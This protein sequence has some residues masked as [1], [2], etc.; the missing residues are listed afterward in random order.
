MKVETNADVKELDERL[1]NELGIDVRKYR[2][3]EV[4]ENFMEILLFPQYIGSWV[5]RP[6][7]LLLILFFLGFFFIDLVH[8]EYLIYAVFGL[9]LTLLTGLFLGLLLFTWRLKSDL[10]GIV[11]YALGIMKSGATDLSQVSNKITPDNRKEVLGL[12][13]KGVIHIVTIPMMGEV[14]SKKVPFFGGAIKS[15]LKRV[16]T[17]VSDTVKFDET[18]LEAELNKEDSEPGFIETYTNSISAAT[19]GLNTALSKTMGLAQFPLKIGFLI[20][21]I[22]LVTFLYLIW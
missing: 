8:I 6:I 4:A 20:S 16:L 13:F 12:L 1:K 14:A 17:I 10:I 18:L 3:E 7:I 22:S 19:A 5:L 11:E 9:A 21:M 15:L 2:D